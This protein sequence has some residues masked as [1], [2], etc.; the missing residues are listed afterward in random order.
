MTCANFLR[1]FVAAEGLKE[2]CVPSRAA[3]GDV[4][5]VHTRVGVIPG[6][7]GDFFFACFC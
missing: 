5:V 6:L 3:K 2:R 4:Y 1:R 7:I